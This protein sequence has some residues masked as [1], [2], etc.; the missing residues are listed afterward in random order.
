MLQSRDGRCIQTS[1]LRLSPA[2]GPRTRNARLVK[3]CEPDRALRRRKDRRRTTRSRPRMFRISAANGRRRSGAFARRLEGATAGWAEVRS[4]PPTTT[5]PY[6]ILRHRRHRRPP[7][8]L[9]AMGR[10]RRAAPSDATRHHRRVAEPAPAGGTDA[11]ASAQDR[12]SLATTY[13][14][15]GP[16]GPLDTALA[17]RDCRRPDSAL[18]IRPSRQQ[19]DAIAS[20]TGRSHGSARHGCS[21][22]WRPATEMRASHRSARRAMTDVDAGMAR[23]PEP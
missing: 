20:P 5:Q 4:L 11:A 9:A 19:C 13:E 6:F 3:T 15:I 1:G 23:T 12:G 7:P 21:G 10:G 16:Y 14:R 8:V 2:I 22:S 17:S 18:C